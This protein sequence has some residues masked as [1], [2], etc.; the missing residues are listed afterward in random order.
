MK[1]K[2]HD[3]KTYVSYETKCNGYAATVAITPEGEVQWW[4]MNG[5]DVKAKGPA[6]SLSAAKKAVAEYITGKAA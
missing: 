5:F 6:K 2:K 4:I 1:W 3:W